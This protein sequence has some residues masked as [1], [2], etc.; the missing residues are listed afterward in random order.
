MIKPVS[1]V[2]QAIES[3]VVL[4]EY[5]DKYSQIQAGDGESEQRF[6]ADEGEGGA[7]WDYITEDIP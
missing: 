3:K 1:T 2:S 6:C 7:L 4:E 5:F